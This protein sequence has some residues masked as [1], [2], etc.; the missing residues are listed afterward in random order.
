MVPVRGVRIFGSHG[1]E[2]SW[3]GG[4]PH[5]VR[6]PGP[7]ARDNLRKITRV[8]AK[9]ASGVPGAYLERKPQGIALHDR[10][11]AQAR[12]G[13]WRRRVRELLAASDLEGLEVLRG[14]RVIE[15]R[16][17]GHH[18]GRVVERLLAIA[19]PE[20]CDRSLLALGDDRTDEDMFRALQGRGLPVRVGRPRKTSLAERRLPSP[21]SVARFLLHLAQG[22]RRR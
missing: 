8:A 16:P 1:A 21:A 22:T 14:R 17:W 10:N 3:N 7:V 5:P 9:L 20:R 19:S 2:G 4:D 15:V 18:K 13:S 6:Q 11:L 12:L